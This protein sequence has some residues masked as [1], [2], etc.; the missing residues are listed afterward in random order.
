MQNN[1]LSR[2]FYRA[3]KIFRDITMTCQSFYFAN[4]LKDKK[5]QTYFYEWNQTIL[6]PILEHLG[7]PAG[8]GPIHT[9]E[10]AYM[11]GKPLAR[12]RQRVPI[13][14]FAC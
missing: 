8:M 5:N 13:Q 4:H 10:F 3:A 1:K 12:Q 6:D 2:E 9:S 11:F 14:S 7:H